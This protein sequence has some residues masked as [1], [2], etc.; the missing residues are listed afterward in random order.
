MNFGL[1]L[2]VAT[3]PPN[4]MW[5]HMS[6]SNHPDVWCDC[7]CNYCGYSIQSEYLSNR[8]RPVSC[9]GPIKMSSWSHIL[10]NSQKAHYDKCRESGRGWS[11]Q[12]VLWDLTKIPVHLISCL[13]WALFQAGIHL[14]GCREDWNEYCIILFLVTGVS[15]WVLV[16]CFPYVILTALWFGLCQPHPCFF[17]YLRC[18]PCSHLR[19]VSL[20]LLY[21]THI[22]M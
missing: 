19:Y 22:L 17:S 20:L 4:V 1:N 2:P 21:C 6:S 18:C 15:P 5:L 14:E 16:L 3:N 7:C 13:C 10:C 12:E 11:L 8:W 9:A